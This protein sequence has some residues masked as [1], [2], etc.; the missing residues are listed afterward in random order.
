MNRSLALLAV[1][2]AFLAPPLSEGAIISIT[3]QDDLNNLIVGQEVTFDLVLSG[4]GACEELS[5]LGAVV[6][7]NKSIFGSPTILTAMPIVPDV[8]GFW[9]DVFPDEF[10][11][12]VISGLYEA[13]FANN[14]DLVVSDG[15]FF[16][17]TLTALQPGTGEI[18]LT[19]AYIYQDGI[20]LPAWELSSPVALP[21]TVNAASEGAVPEPSTLVTLLGL[22]AVFGAGMRR[23]RRPP[24]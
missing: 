15:V 10:P 17:F 18:S 12:A 19:D 24:A 21:F 7:Y 16:S 8:D 22:G 11:A 1:V 2:I 3:S 9:G 4:L 23:R 5:A 14:Y 6:E 20:D 13:L